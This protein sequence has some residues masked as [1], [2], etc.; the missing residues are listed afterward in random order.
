MQFATPKLSKTCIVVW[1]LLS[2]LNARAGDPAPVKYEGDVFKLSTD[3]T[4]FTDLNRTKNADGTVKEYRAP[5]TSTFIVTG[6]EKI[7]DGEY[8]FWV[9]IK[10]L[11]STD[12]FDMCLGGNASASSDGDVRENN[13]YS[14]NFREKASKDNPPNTLSSINSVRQAWT[15]G[16]LVVPFKFRTTDHSITGDATIGAYLGRTWYLAGATFTPILSA[17]ISQIAVSNPQDNTKTDTRTGFTVAP[18]L[19]WTI[20]EN[21]QIGALVGWDY[22]G[23]NGEQPWKYNGKTW[24]SFAIGYQFV[25]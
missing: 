1:A 18:G 4:G 23:S 19:I 8:T 13:T 11:G 20:K 6:E 25:K 9:R 3:V 22:I 7:K 5:T 24:L 10:C 15:F 16:T 2:S 21:F 17:G 14:V 12:F